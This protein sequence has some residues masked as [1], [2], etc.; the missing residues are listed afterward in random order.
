MSN[1]TKNEDSR[2][3]S[4]GLYSFFYV[5]S[6]SVKETRTGILRA[7][8]TWLYTNIKIIFRRTAYIKKCLERN[9]NLFDV[10]DVTYF[11][12]RYRGLVKLL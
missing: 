11:Y 10:E 4:G 8:S 5:K 7:A 3:D 12:T 1:M 2:N 9:L 6:E